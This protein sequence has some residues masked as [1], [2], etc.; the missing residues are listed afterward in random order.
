MIAFCVQYEFLVHDR[1]MPV[2][3]IDANPKERPHLHVFEPD[4]SDRKEPLIDGGQPLAG[5]FHEAV[6]SIQDTFEK[7]KERFI[8]R[9]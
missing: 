9:L 4:G 8:N 1:W 6:A 5:A 2:V 7:Q 3:R